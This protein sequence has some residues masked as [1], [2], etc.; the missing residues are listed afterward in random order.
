MSQIDRIFFIY[1][2][3]HKLS[4]FKKK[5]SLS[6]FDEYFFSGLRRKSIYKPEAEVDLGHGVIGAHLIFIKIFTLFFV[7]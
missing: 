7:K 3:F 4:G 2:H 5:H 1:F 6:P